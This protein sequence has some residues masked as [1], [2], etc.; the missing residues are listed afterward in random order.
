[1]RP[2]SKSDM[3]Q[4]LQVANN[5]LVYLGKQDKLIIGG[6]YGGYQVQ[7]ESKIYPY[8]IERTLTGFVSKRE[9]YNFLNTYIEGLSAKQE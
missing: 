5:S 1:M 3:Y 7:I 9:V 8:C 4:I 2:I 6:A